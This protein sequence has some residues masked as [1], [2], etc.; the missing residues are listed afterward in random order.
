MERLL[1]PA[2]MLSKVGKLLKP[3]GKVVVIVPLEAPTRKISPRDENHHLFSWNVQ[4]FNGFLA[5]CGYSVRS[6][7][8]K[9]YGCDRFAAE[10]AV[11][12][13]GGFAFYKLLLSILRTI[14]P[15]YEIQAV[16]GYEVKSS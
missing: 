5:A 12:F 14:R 8:V 16:A 6:C 1:E 11:R 10:L 2:Q 4:T 9:R 7:K 15:D 13:G 3:E